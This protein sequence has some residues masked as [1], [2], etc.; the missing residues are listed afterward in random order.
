MDLL[1]LPPEQ[2]LDFWLGNWKVTDSSGKAGTNHVL[3][4]MDEKVIQENFEFPGPFKGMSVSVYSP[5]IE[6]WRQTWVDT[7]G[8]YWAFTGIV[9]AD[10][11]IFQC[12][13]IREGV[14]VKLRMVFHN[15][16]KD[17]LDWSWETSKDGGVTW[18]Q[19]WFLRYERVM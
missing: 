3:R 8:S 10:R 2:Q 9:E 11:F 5:H 6:Q 19:T 4:M 7:G 1:T 16:E 13:D 18:E 15:I 14:P 17:S 12:D